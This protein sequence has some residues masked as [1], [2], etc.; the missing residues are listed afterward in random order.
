MKRKLDELCIKLPSPLPSPDIN[1][2]SPEPDNEYDLPD[3]DNKG[4]DHVNINT[5]Q[6]LI[7]VLLFN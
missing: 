2:P 4:F 7:I 5:K 6:Y 3:L 1:A